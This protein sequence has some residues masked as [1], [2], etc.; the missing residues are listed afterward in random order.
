MLYVYNL[1]LWLW[2]LHSLITHIPFLIISLYLIILI[3]FQTSCC[4]T[5]LLFSS[6]LCWASNLVID[7]I[8]AFVIS[9]LICW[10][11]LLNALSTSLIRKNWL[12]YSLVLGFRRSYLQRRA[13][14]S[15]VGIDVWHYDSHSVIALFLRLWGFA[16]GIPWHHLALSSWSNLIRFVNSHR[17]VSATRVSSRWT[18]IGPAHIRIAHRRWLAFAFFIHF[19]LSNQLFLHPLISAYS[20]NLCFRFLKDW[21]RWHLF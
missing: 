4:V 3:L 14:F 6:L 20:L 9:L 13:Y 10:S 11:I 15:L 7:L 19:S 17:R 1:L 8:Y 2:V 16:I 18:A 12:L 5:W 21:I